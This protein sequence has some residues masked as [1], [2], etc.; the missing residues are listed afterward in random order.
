MIPNVLTGQPK[1]KLK[2]IILLAS[3]FPLVTL[4]FVSTLADSNQINESQIQEKGSRIKHSSG[5][6]LKHIIIT[7]KEIEQ[8]GENSAAD[9]L[10][11][12]VVNSTGSFRPQSGSPLQGIATLDI[13]G[14]GTNKTLILIDGRR[15]A[16]SAFSGD[17]H[18]LTTIALSQIERIEI[19]PE[20]ASAVYGADA[21]AGV[22]N[23]ITRTD[24]D[25]LE[26]SIGGGTAGLPESGGDRHNASLIF[27]KTYDNIKVSGGIGWN[28]RDIIYLRDEYFNTPGSSVYANNYTTLSSGGFDNFDWQTIP[29]GSSN[30]ACDSEDNAFFTLGQRCAYDFTL[31][32]A[33]EASSE[34]RSV[35]L[36]S[37]M[38]LNDQ[39]LLRSTISHAKS[40]SFGRYAPAP[41]SSYFSTPLS[42]SSPNNP[43]NPNG[44]YY[45][46]ARFPDGAE[47][48]NW[49]H[50]FAAIGNRDDNFESKLTDIRL[51]IS[52]TSATMDWD[53]GLRYSNYETSDIGKNY[54]LR[55]EALQAIESGSYSLANPLS[56]GESVLNNLRTSIAREGENKFS[57]IWGNA[58]LNLFRIADRQVRANFGIEYRNETMRDI[59]DPILEAGRVGGTAVNTNRV[60]VQYLNNISKSGK[61]NMYAY[62]ADVV[63]PATESI[64]ISL[65]ARNDKYENLDTQFSNQIMMDW[66]LFDGFNWNISYSEDFSVARLDLL[67]LEPRTF[68]SSV[69]LQLID[70]FFPPLSESIIPTTLTNEFLESETSTSY[71]TRFSYQFRESDFIALRY[72]DTQIENRARFFGAQESVIY[73]TFQLTPIAN[74]GLGLVTNDRGAITSVIHGYGNLGTVDLQAL[75]LDM[76][77]NYGSE[78]ISFNHTLRANQVRSYKV[79]GQEQTQISLFHPKL[80]ASL[81]N[82][83]AFADF[84]LAWNFNIIGRT[85]GAQPSDSWSTHDI[86]LN[87]LSKWGTFSVGAL[88]VLEEKPPIDTGNSGSRNY[89]FDLYDADGRVTYLRYQVSF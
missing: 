67:S 41:D 35:W 22:V 74:T 46:A 63:I 39:I 43:S 34:N 82:S 38:Q 8:S 77:I 66:R 15:L 54:V 23:I 59:K 72:I 19:L 12:M 44:F 36:N 5:K 10:R 16:R 76:N 4:P 61:R 47:P 13:F 88:N 75:T 14:M 37:S 53:I 84:E 21:I 11:N 73:S 64:D 20:S 29:D 89:D 32:S 60:T 58:T 2:K 24:F 25:G 33:H 26:L 42:A 17:V 40:S 28:N 57:E 48:I 69:P 7:R 81:K 31:V 51:A 30:G 71:A 79:D 45:D 85:S 55:D 65:R 68:D 86:Q 78:L 49:W 87:Y 70:G 18:D 27:G 56:S 80:R 9:F 6:S 3:S 50:R 52:G 62:F 1:H 83:M